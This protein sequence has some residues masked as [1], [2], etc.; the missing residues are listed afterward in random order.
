M[1][2][3]WAA[4]S[5]ETA[6]RFSAVGYYF[7]REL[8]KRLKVPVGM[9]SSSVGGTPAEAWTSHDALAANPELKA[10]F[11]AQQSANPIVRS[12]EPGLSEQMTTTQFQHIKLWFAGKLGKWKLATYELEHLASGLNEA[13]KRA[14]V[15]VSA[16]FWNWL[17]DSRCKSGACS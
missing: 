10:I 5:P 11:E 17:R 6:P 1:P 3:K 4:A 16:F 7:A 8:R 2:G 12:D 15:G 13:A 9:L 14:P